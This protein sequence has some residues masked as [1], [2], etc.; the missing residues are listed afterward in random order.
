MEGLIILMAAFGLAGMGC[1][2]YGGY[3]LWFTNRLQRKGMALEG[4]IVHRVTRSAWSG[5]SISYRYE[6]EGK[7]YFQDQRITIRHIDDYDPG[8]TVTVY[9]FPRHPARARMRDTSWYTS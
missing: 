8:R 6:C 3:Q 9:C 5:C 1:V 2:A 7:D 4:T